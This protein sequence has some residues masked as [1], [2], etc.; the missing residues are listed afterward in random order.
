MTK[1]EVALE[2]L[3]NL[4]DGLNATEFPMGVWERTEFNLLVKLR[5]DKNKAEAAI[6]LLESSEELSH[7]EVMHRDIETVYQVIEK[8]IQSE[9]YPE[10]KRCASVKAEA[11]IKA[12]E[13]RGYKITLPKP[14]E[15]KESIADA[16]RIPL[17]NKHELMP[18]FPVSKPVEGD[19]RDEAIQILNH[20]STEWL[21]IPAEIDK[22][23][24]AEFAVDAL[25]SNF[26]FT[27]KG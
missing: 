11:V 26:N 4:V 2:A 1:Q 22:R 25:L 10:T 17:D 18:L 14:V 12:L 8:A 20:S 9:P 15:P 24:A 16:I 6:K 5:E 23:N 13:D 3:K 27:R 19:V 21:D 7:E